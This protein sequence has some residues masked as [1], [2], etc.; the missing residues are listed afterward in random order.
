MSKDIWKCKNK[1][2][3]A[4]AAIGL[5]LILAIIIPFWGWILAAGGALVYTGWC[6]ISSNK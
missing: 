6:L 5:G 2:G 4:V 1:I 3:I